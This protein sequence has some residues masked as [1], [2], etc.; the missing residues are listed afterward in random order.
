[1]RY[2]ASETAEKHTR[3]LEQAARLFRVRGFSGVSVSEIMKAT[4]LTHGAF[5]NHFESKD[6]LMVECIAHASEQSLQHLGQAQQSPRQM[7]DY[8]QLYLS[9]AHRDAPGEG[10]VMAALAGEIAREPVVK[11]CF[12]AHFKGML[13]R[14]SAHFPWASKRS[15]RRD[16]IRM[17]SSM[18]G[19]VI[20]ARA[21]DDSDLSDEIL[22]EVAAQFK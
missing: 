18:V 15:A 4:G 20:L 9:G 12:T 7:L 5:Y 1:M 2:P 17:I 13:T 3:I 16:A 19:A 22:R 10:C 6:A 14:L 21:L 8:V 11:A